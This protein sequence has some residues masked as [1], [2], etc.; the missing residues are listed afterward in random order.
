MM[1][2]HFLKMHRYLRCPI[3]ALL[4][5]WLTLSTTQHT[6]TVEQFV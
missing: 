4:L 1:V 6:L 5:A 2:K 3:R